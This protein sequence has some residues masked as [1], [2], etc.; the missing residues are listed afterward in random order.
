MAFDQTSWTAFFGP[1]GLPPAVVERLS[2][3]VNTILKSPEEHKRFETVNLRLGTPSTPADLGQLVKQDM[4]AW[5]EIVKIAGV[6]P[7]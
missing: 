1:K 7:E 2:A 6:K 3:A 5:G 4:A